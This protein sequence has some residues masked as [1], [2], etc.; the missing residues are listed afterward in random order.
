MCDPHFQKFVPFAKSVRNFSLRT[1]QNSEHRSVMEDS[2]KVVDQW[3]GNRYT[4]YFSVF[5]GHGGTEA[6]LFVKNT[7]HKAIK[8]ELQQHDDDMVAAIVAA[9]NAIDN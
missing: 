1:N 4:G 3:L 8:A 5:D 7:L 2:F 9:F 6:V